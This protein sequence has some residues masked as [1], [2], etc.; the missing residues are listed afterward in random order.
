[1]PIIKIRGQSVD[2]DIRDEL[3]RYNWTRPRWT[4]DKLIAA[5]PFRYDQTPSFYVYLNGDNAGYWGDSGF[6]DDEWARGGFVK[7]LAFLRNETREETEEYLICEY[8]RLYDDSGKIKLRVPELSPKK[9]PNYLPPSTLARY[10]DNYDYLEGRGIS[11][12]VQ[13]QARVKY[14]RKS[15]AILIPWFDSNGR[16]CNVKYRKTRGKVFWYERGAVPISTLIYGIERVRASVAVLEEAEIDALSWTEVGVQGIAVGGANFTD[17]QADVI[18]RSPITTL[19]ISGDNDKAGGK[20]MKQV[21]DKLRGYVEL[22]QITKPI[23]VKDTNEA[24]VK[25]CDIRQMLNSARC[26]TIVTRKY[27]K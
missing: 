12:D 13:R 16:L 4:G 26:V 22:R 17:E 20:F 6:Y 2:V 25:D 11:A 7:L 19:Y 9:A 15:N 10:E 24:L 3:E 23:G 8:G 5:S 21:E 14:D 27:I 1:M 18:K